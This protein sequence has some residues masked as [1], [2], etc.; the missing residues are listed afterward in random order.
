MAMASRMAR[1][2]RAPFVACLTPVAKPRRPKA[3]PGRPRGRSPT[4][5]RL[6]PLLGR[7]LQVCRPRLQPTTRTVLAL[8]GAHEPVPSYTRQGDESSPQRCRTQFPR[9]RSVAADLRQHL[10]RV[11]QIHG[12]D[13]ERG[14]GCATF[15]DALEDQASPCRP[16]VP[17]AVRLSR[18][19][20][21]HR[22]SIR[23]A[24][25]VPPPRIRGAASGHR[26]GPHSRHHQARQLPHPATLV[27]D[28]PARRRLRYPHGAGTDRP[29]R[30]QHDH[31][32]HPRP[33]PRWPRRPKPCGSAVGPAA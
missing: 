29:R 16:R 30:R 28:P 23:R 33:E 18:G 22:P 24:E 7:H 9:G 4:R 12:S 17:V 19:S 3:D 14:F 21:V 5:R 2:I 11:H 10:A 13:L 31:D 26:R 6:Q 25:Q 32:L 20:T 1:R 8:P 15:P 27:R